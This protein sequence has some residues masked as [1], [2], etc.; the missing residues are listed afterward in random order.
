MHG[1][2]LQLHRDAEPRRQRASAGGGLHAE[3][4]LAADT[5]RMQFAAQA[6]LVF[7]VC[8]HVH[9]ESGKS[10]RALQGIVRKRPLQVLSRAPGFR[11][12][13]A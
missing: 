3:D 4:V 1:L 11:V 9:R 2:G 12:S 13:V 10:H 8:P 5:I 6:L 7:R